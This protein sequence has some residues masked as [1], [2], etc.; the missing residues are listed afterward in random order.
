VGILATNL[1]DVGS[2]SD[3][4]VYT[5]ASIS[6][7]TGSIILVFVHSQDAA[8][9]PAP[10]VS[11]N[12]LTFTNQG[13]VAYDTAGSTG[14]VTLWRAFASAPSA[15][16]LTATFSQTQQACDIIVDQFTGC[17]TSGTNG[18]DAVLQ[19]VYG[20]IDTSSATPSITLVPFAKPTNA[21]V[22]YF[23]HQ[24]NEG[25]TPGAGFA[26]LGDANRAGPS[27]G[28]FS[29]WREG[30][31]DVDASWATSAKWSGFGVELN[32][33]AGHINLLL[34]GMG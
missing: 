15:G 32:A 21:A 26:E 11:G 8:V 34:L 33:Q 6:P 17:I 23:A 22:G 10:T 25:T 2:G 30:D 24:A 20:P 7:A 27:A 4:T 18:A 14:R 19:N 13:D 5:T 12:G 1:A 28:V 9:A 29:E 16:V 31:D 3:N